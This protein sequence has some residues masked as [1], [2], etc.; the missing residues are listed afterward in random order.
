MNVINY[1]N[2][3]SIPVAGGVSRFAGSSH[4][5]H[6]GDM[7]VAKDSRKIEFEIEGNIY[8][9]Y[10]QTLRYCE[11]LGIEPGQ[12]HDIIA[13]KKIAN[14]DNYINRYRELRHFIDNTKNTAPRTYKINKAKVRKRLIALC[15]LK[16]SKNFLAFYSISFPSSAPDT[17]LYEIFNRWLTTCREHHGLETY[18]W[19]AERQKNGTL[20]FHVLTNNWLDIAKVNK[21]MATAI[22]TS[23]L[24]EKLSWKQSSMRLYNGVDVDS[25]NHPKQR[26][27][28][29]REQYRRRLHEI[30][31]HSIKERINFAIKYMTKYMTKGD[32]VFYHLPFHSSRDISQLFTS[33]I[34]TDKDFDNYCQYLSDDEEDYVIYFNEKYTIYAFKKIQPDKLYRML[35]RLNNILFE[36][37][38]NKSSPAELTAESC[39]S[40]N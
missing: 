12:D 25:I 10:L 9:N 36:M 22:N 32:D 3:T 14:Y 13:R 7:L 40:N 18:I 6:I 31:K 24:Q 19:V 34:L 15:R 39:Y 4:W 38:H 16:Q 30:R 17:A 20:H 2:V 29:T 23:V 35:D 21:A 37:Y 26:Q 33:M 11:I 27:G 1:S 8:K 5:R 28:E